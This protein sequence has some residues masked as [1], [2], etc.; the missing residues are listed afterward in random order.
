MTSQHTAVELLRRLVE[1]PSPSGQE[2][3]A[4]GYL[5]AAMGRLGLSARIDEVGNAVGET[6]R[7]AG[8]TV[9]LLG[10]IDTV[11]G[12]VPV[13]RENGRLYG[14]GAVDAKGPLAAMVLAA[15]AAADF[16]GRVVVVGAVEE[17]SS[18]RGAAHLT[19][20]MTRPNWV[21]VGEP[22]GWTQP[23]LGYKGKLDLVYRVR[24][25]ATH[26]SNPAE[27]A[28][29]AAAAF[30]ADAVGLLGADRGHVSFS[31]LAV[32]LGAMHGDLT[33][34][35]LEICYRT[36]VG[37]D[38][39]AL[40]AALRARARGGEVEVAGRVRAVAVQRRNPVARALAAGIRRQGGTP[41]PTLKT[42]TSDMNTLAEVWDVPMATYGPGDSAL[43]HAADEHI[44]LDDYLRAV[45]VLSAAMRELGEEPQP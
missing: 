4:V 32:T 23:V 41:R 44:V 22:G 14:R 11:P 25:S 26:P 6:G 17:E 28:S 38:D 12:D 16:P 40:V 37:F 30:W 20:A 15:A 39:E 21:V 19:R 43:D 7:G 8:P 24:R 42:G 34:A 18:S 10:H 1:I 35:E 2:D 3:R 9:L 36:P 5:I 13:R 45:G 31:R 29:E 33:S 27:K